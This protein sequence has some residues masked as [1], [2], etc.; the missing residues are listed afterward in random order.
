MLNT[1]ILDAQNKYGV[2]L[3][4]DIK[5]YRQYFD[6]AVRLLGIQ[7]VYYAPRPGKHYTNYTEIKT[8]FQEPEVIGVIFEDHPNQRSMKKMGWVSEL[9]ENASLIHVPYD[10][11]DVQA[12]ALFAVPS[13][14]DHTSGRLFRVVELQNSMVYPA[15][16]ACL[17]VPEYDNILP[18]SKQDVSHTDFNLLADDGEDTWMHGDAPLEEDV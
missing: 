16:I 8:N 15:S 12:G 17:I 4:P 2:L 6:E 5:I 7:V 18:S 10:L 14:L 13:G 11:H 9:Q 1:P 3:T